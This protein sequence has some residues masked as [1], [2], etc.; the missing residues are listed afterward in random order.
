MVGSKGRNQRPTWLYMYCTYH[1]SFNQATK[2]SLNRP[3]KTLMCT[4]RAI[5]LHGQ[6]HCRPRQFSSYSG[7]LKGRVLVYPVQAREP[8]ISPPERIGKV[9]VEQ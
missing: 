4:L 7:M 1:V 9:A 2:Y 5:Q 6:E 3:S 8:L